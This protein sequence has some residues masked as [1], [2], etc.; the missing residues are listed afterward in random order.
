MKDGWETRRL[1]ELFQIGS[2]KRVLKTQWTTE[3]VPFYRGR[4]I[5]RLAIDGFVD[6]KLF[7]SEEHY[8]ELA[9]KFG[10][11]TAGDIVITAIGTIGNS[12]VV[13]EADRFYFKDAS[14]L[15]MKRTANVGTRFIN[16]W[17]K[18]PLFFDQL[19]RGNGATVD[20]LTIQK[21][22]SVRVSVPPL[23]E[24]QRIVGI[25]DEAFEAIATAKAN[26]EK[27]LQNARALFESHLHSVFSQ[28]GEGWVERRLKQ[29]GMTQTGSTPKTSDKT[30]YGDFIPFIKPSDFN[31]D[32]SLNYENEGLS[33][34]GL[35]EA[36]K[37][38]AG[39]VLMV[40]IGAT[41]G[42]CGYCDRDVTTNQQTNALT[43]IDGVSHKFVYYQM[44]TENFQRRISLSSGQATLPI[45][46]K[47]KWST[48]TVALPPRF[49]EQR[50]I[51]AKLDALREETQKLTF[52]YERKLEALDEL[53]KSLLH[54]AFSGNLS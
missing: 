40:C 11:P 41:I 38:E 16:A 9:G 5:T 32:G 53:K 21:L 3:G 52:L 22:Q 7:I 48:L 15:W 4:E 33:E 42:K 1:G 23:P 44:L 29:I 45:I 28:R 36:R 2:S 13:R 12:H 50:K 8:A 6:N 26:A 43:P 46:N 39:S 10:T 18:S 37:V 54:Q 30:N 34:K 17:L 35:A 14:V 20:T 27:N 31:Q 24:Q 51:V 25:L 47:S 49:E 19:D